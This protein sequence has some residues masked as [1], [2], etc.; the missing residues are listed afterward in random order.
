MFGSVLSCFTKNNATS[1][2]GLHGCSSFFS[3]LCCTIDFIFQI[4]QTSS[5]FEPRQPHAYEE[6]SVGFESIT[7]GEIFSIKKQ[8]TRALCTPRY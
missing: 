3:Q 1:F 8:W 4:T 2:P 5:K 7:N 6:L